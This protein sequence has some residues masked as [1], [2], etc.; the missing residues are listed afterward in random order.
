MS[1]PDARSGLLLVEPPF[2]RRD[3]GQL[4]DSDRLSAGFTLAELAV[5]TALVLILAGIAMPVT[6]FAMKRSKE[7]ELRLSLRRM[8]NSIDEYKRYSDA[9][10]LEIEFETEGYPAE[11]E[12]LVEGVP[13]VGQIDRESRFLRVI[14]VDPM[15]GEE[16]WGLR[17]Y[18]DDPDSQSWGG[19]NVFDV[20]SLSEGVGLNGVPYA[21]W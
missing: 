1:I 10:L 13:I 3:R 12:R 20:Y 4:H 2:S 21:Q 17:S 16:E 7:A 18:Q 6:K 5:V 14:P 19:S 9:G 8:R 11:L 15:T